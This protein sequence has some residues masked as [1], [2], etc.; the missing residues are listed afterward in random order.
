MSEL[1]GLG[2][3]Q[4]E[5]AKFGGRLLG[6]SVDAPERSGE[7]VRRNGL[8]FALLTD[9]DAAVIRRYGVLH[10]G[11]G[12]QGNDVALP[13]LFLIDRDGRIV[14]RRIAIRIQDRP[15]PRTIIAEVQKRFGRAP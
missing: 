15:D 3:V 14:W 13:A 11:G 10:A 12:D 7:V 4:D 5:L 9:S 1:R 6:I 8:R 2:A